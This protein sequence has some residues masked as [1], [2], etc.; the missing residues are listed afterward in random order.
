MGNPPGVGSIPG[1]YQ[2]SSGEERVWLASESSLSRSTH[3]A[4][5]QAARSLG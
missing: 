5:I 3:P 2:V 4:W 1:G